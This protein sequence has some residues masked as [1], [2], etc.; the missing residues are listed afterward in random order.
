MARRSWHLNRRTFLRGTGLSLALPWLEAMS[1]AEPSRP[2]GR[3]GFV[4]S[5]SATAWRFQANPPNTNPKTT[6][7]SDNESD[8][9][10]SDSDEGWTWFPRT[11]GSDYELTKSLEP[12]APFGAT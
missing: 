3:S 12:L 6:N 9:K 11:G 2:S 5:S 4:P 8:H 1:K 10:S 7:S